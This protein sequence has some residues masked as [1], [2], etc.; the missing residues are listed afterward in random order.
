MYIDFCSGCINTHTHTHT[1]TN[2]QGRH[3]KYTEYSGSTGITKEY[4]QSTLHLPSVFWSPAA[5][6][7]HESASAAA[8]A[9]SL[10]PPPPVYAAIPA[11][12]A[13]IRDFASARSWAPFHRPRNLF[14]ALSGELGELAEQVQVLSS[15]I[16]SS[17]SRRDSEDDR[18]PTTTTAQQ[19]DKLAQ[20]M[21]DVAIYLL[22]LADVCGID[23]VP[24]CAQ[25]RSLSSASSSEEGQSLSSAAAAAAIS[26]LP[27]LPAPEQQQSPLS[28]SL[29]G[30]DSNHLPIPEIRTWLIRLWACCAPL[31]TAVAS[32]L[33]SGDELTTATTTATTSVAAD[34]LYPM[35]LA[36]DAMAQLLYMDFLSEANSVDSCHPTTTPAMAKQ[37]GEVRRCLL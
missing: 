29:V 9:A 18:T 26:S 13:E 17:Y 2:K 23:L 21:A 34:L 35:F 33:S 11:L 24:A 32:F 22:R 1:Q 19:W 4:G 30:A 10:V 14:L 25:I 15:S 27:Q 12:S 5:Q 6:K 37:N 31:G 28:N 7:N 3:S 36:L 20:E 16:S 8:A